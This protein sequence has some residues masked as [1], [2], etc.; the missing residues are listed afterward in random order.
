[1]TTE[2]K[3]FDLFELCAALL[4]GI[5]AIGAALAGFEAN[6]WGSKQMEAY[7]E[8]NQKMTEA[9]REYNEGMSIINADFAAVAAAKAQVIEGRESGDGA[10]RQKHFEIASYIFTT[11]LS[12]P[13]YKL[14]GLPMAYYVEDEETAAAPAASAPAAAPAPAPAGGTEEAESEGEVEGEEDEAPAPATAAADRDLPSEAL[15]ATLDEEL[16]DDY[17]DAILVKGEQM[18]TE[19]KARFEEGNKCDNIG[20]M[21]DLAGIA[22]TM[23]LFFGGLALIF[24]TKMRWYFWGAGAVITG[25]SYIFM[26]FQP[27]TM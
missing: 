25:V 6:Q 22:F 23:A 17:I 26:L 19:A 16:D 21:F 4:L 10:T 5:G 15:L 9:A 11:Q 7:G 27:W 24:K 3:P 20:D 2:E 13:A 18:A 12:E 14:M 8:S 1:M